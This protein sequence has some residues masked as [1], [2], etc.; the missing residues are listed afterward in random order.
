MNNYTGSMDLF[1]TKYTE[2]FE[3]D[4]DLICFQSVALLLHLNKRN[5][6]ISDISLFT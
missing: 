1:N 6:T 4:I 3:Y 2:I 5:P